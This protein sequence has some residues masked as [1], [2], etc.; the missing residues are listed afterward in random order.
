MEPL[1]LIVIVVAALGGAGL[2]WYLGNRKAAALRAE[3]DDYMQRCRDALKDIDI[4]KRLNERIPNLEA[5][6]KT[7]I[8]ARDEALRKITKLETEAANFDTR[9]QEFV[10][11]QDTLAVKFG[12]V[13][14]KLLS[15]AKQQFFEQAKQT[16]G[17]TEKAA[18]AKISALLAPVKDTLA[19]YEEGVTKV[20]NDRREAYGT[21]TGL[22]EGMRTGQEAVRSEAAKLVLS[23]RGN[24]K[25]PGRWGEKHFQNLIEL[26]GL[27]P[28][29]DYEREKSFDL[30][31]GRIR[32]DY[33]I[34][35]P[36][37]QSLVVDIKCSVDHYISA[38]E[39]VVQSE[40]ER[41]LDS[42]AQSVLAHA[43]ALSKKSY[44]EHLSDAPEYVIMYI[45]GDNFFS[46]ALEADPGLWDRSAKKGVIISC[47]STFLP[48][49]HSLANMWRSFKLEKDA[50]EVA[51][52]GKDLYARM[53]AM[54]DNLRLVG[55][56]I[57]SAMDNYN[58]FLGSLEGS[59]LPQARKFKELSIDTANRE[60]AELAPVDRVLRE[61][62]TGRDLIF[63]V[64]DPMASHPAGET[65]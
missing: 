49:A 34:R 46:A 23:L 22:I 47:P 3:R 4:E 42:H 8:D 44:T 56:G 12:E 9:L 17:Q 51:R 24:P 60:I 40:R 6:L 21:L 13:G 20:E 39:S 26:A 30:E 45:P 41:Y 53:C 31:S 19:R 37:G 27:A 58:S 35:L 54:T 1:V 48:L 29:V 2:G 61:P 11:A 28:F 18:E 16:F 59:V 25:T 10:A 55:K 15:E 14:S 36:G 64:K 57:L 38:V 7:V 33:V 5:E 43:D 32:P 52:L 62:V 63:E 65:G 50:A